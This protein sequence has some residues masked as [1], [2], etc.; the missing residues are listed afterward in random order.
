MIL[1]DT[2]CHLEVDEL[3]QA[4]PI[5]ERA[6][7]Q[8]VVHSVIVGQLQQPG[9]FG[10]S[11]P[12]ARAHPESLTATMG[13]HP[14]DAAKA[15]DADW[16]ELERLCALPEIHAV[17]E[18]G[19]DYY[20]DHSPRD[21][22]ALAFRR[23]CAL[24]K[25]LNKPIVIHVRDA[26]DDCARILKDEGMQRGMIHCFTGNTDEARRYLDLGFHLSIAGV[27]TYKKTEAL[28]EAARFAPADRL[29]IETDSP[30]LSPMPL[31]G[32]K[33]EPANVA[34]T[35]KYLA[36]LRGVEAEAF[37][38]RCAHNSKA[39]LSLPVDLPAL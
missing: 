9:D 22:Q 35:A 7:A 16:A 32:K 37:A 25:A 30:F 13:I 21:V 8:G 20:Y 18:A 33:N 5:L 4:A 3:A 14:H 15:T 36:A 10:Q 6:K 29:M 17:G 2:H 12:L 1:I 27:V 34:L 38:L 23:Q 19:L 39:L 26:H 24:A 31:R 11:L 28:N